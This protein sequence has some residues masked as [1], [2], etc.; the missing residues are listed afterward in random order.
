[1]KTL[2]KSLL[3]T[4]AFA[5][6]SPAFA[7]TTLKFAHAAPETDLQQNL[8]TFF[9][10]EV[11]KRTDGEVTVQIFPQGQLGN[12]GAMIDGARSGIIDVVMVGL[13]NFSGLMPDSAA[14]TL[15]FMFPDRETAYSVLDGEVGKGVLAK[16]EDHGLKG[17][18]FPENGYR[19]MTNSRG[20]IRTP[21]DVKGLRMR[22]NNSKALNDMF[23]LLDAQPQ[24]IPVAELYTALETGVVDS[25]D[26][27]IG[28]TLSFKFYE[29]Q[30]YLSLTQHAYAPLAVA[31]NLSKFDGLTPEQQQIILDVSEEA[32]DMQRQMSID[33]EEKMIADLEAEGMEVNRDVDAAAFQAVVAPVWD[34]FIAE[35]GDTLVNA[36][37]AATAK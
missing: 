35:N 31:M 18:G 9:A 33:S 6:C 10:D 28:V 14:L 26:H 37:K 21:E 3:I 12:D 11:A 2:L 17:L 24:Q 23:Q 8:A 30:K 19:N 27:P 22:V 32:V 7:Q 34:S 16:F 36:I 25:Q 20:P 5:L 1:M 4:S 13:N 29:V 15:P